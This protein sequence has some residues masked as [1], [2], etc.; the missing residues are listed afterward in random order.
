MKPYIF[1]PR[2]RRDFAEI[3]DYFG[4]IDPDTALDFV[5]RLQLMCDQ[6][7]EMPG[8]GR[9]R[10]DIAKGL[11]SFPVEKCIIFYRLAKDDIEI[12]RV[13]HG[14]RNIEKIFSEKKR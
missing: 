5:T 2:A 3:L 9:K 12:V 4:E 1:S 13:L 11:R 6:L 8:M 7:A 14:S 10:D